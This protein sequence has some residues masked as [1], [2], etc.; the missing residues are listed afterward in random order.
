MPG[1]AGTE[2]ELFHRDDE[3]YLRWVISNPGGF[4]LNFPRGGGEGDTVLHRAEC[5][6]ITGEPARGESWTADYLKLCSGEKWRLDDW[7]RGELG[8]QPPRCQVCSPG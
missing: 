4:V 7:S 1:S 5:R 3:G 8:F 2:V 6:T